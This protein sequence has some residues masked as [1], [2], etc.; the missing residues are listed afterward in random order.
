[1][2]KIHKT[3]LA[4]LGA[5]AFFAA[6][7]AHAQVADTW[8]IS[9][10]VI[11]SAVNTAT[12]TQLDPIAGGGTATTGVDAAEITGGFKNTISGSAVGASA[13]QSFTSLN[14]SGVGGTA[15]L[16]IGGGVT[17]AAGN[18]S[19]VLNNS[20][21]ATSVTVGGSAN[22]ISLAA[23]GSSA[24]VSGTTTLTDV[25]GAAVGSDETFSYTATGDVS[26]SSG[27]ADGSVDLDQGTTIGGN[28]GTV[29][30]TLA[31]GIAAPAVTGDGNSI[32]VAGVG[33][34][35][36]ASFSATV[37]GDATVLD[38]FALA[39]PQG[40]S[41]SAANDDGADVSVNLNA[42]VT[43]G[44]ITGT[45][46]NSN[47]ISAAAVGSSASFSTSATAFGGATISEFNADVGELQVDSTNGANNVSLANA[48]GADATG[49]DSAVISGGGN[50]NSISLTA[51]GS[52][53]SV[54]ASNTVVSGGLGAET[55]AVNFAAITVNS[56]NGG[57]V[58]NTAS[59]TTAAGISDT[60]SRN[61]ISIAGVGASA[62]QS[63]STTDYSGAGVTGVATTVDGTI[64]L[65]AL[66]TGTVTVAGGLAVP[67]IAD[68]FSNSI[69]A[70]AVGASASQSVARTLVG[71]P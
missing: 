32:S 29:T 26:V 4:L 20:D 48:A 62:S 37:S 53:G 43:G 69:S 6:S 30:L 9:G 5:T 70:A 25:G 14:N 31:T 36:S 58:T 24:S 61:S 64:T 51:V 3:K 59:L 68:G 38:S 10:E 65:A 13:S 27:A 17:V 21:I 63:I 55:G 57:S 7:S 45:G 60:G 33:S 47:S 23:V 22:S 42:G 66:N 44:G 8:G 71:A 50:G 54:S 19:N 1:M 40:A 28:S 18:G 41:V 15:S 35:A 2:T 12:D 11:V 46:G 52:S 16:E 34:S 56:T 67:T 39:L 49:F